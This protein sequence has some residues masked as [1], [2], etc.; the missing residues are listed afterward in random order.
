MTSVSFELYSG[1][2][3]TANNKENGFECH[4]YL[5]EVQNFDHLSVQ[6]ELYLMMYQ[7]SSVGVT[8]KAIST[9]TVVPHFYS[10]TVIQ[11]NEKNTA[12]YA[13]YVMCTKCIWI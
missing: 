12:P 9:D 6:G 1:I 3:A 11:E 4:I 13:P 5:N 10:I 8:Y 7:V 2:T